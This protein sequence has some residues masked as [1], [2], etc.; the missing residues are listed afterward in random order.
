MRT[1]LATDYGGGLYRRRKA[2]VEPVFAQ[3]KHNRR[4]DQLPA[5]RQIRR[6]LGMA[7]DHRDSQPDEAPQAPASR[8]GGLKRH[9]SRTDTRPGPQLGL[10]EHHCHGRW[11]SPSSCGNFARHPRRSA[12]IQD[13]RPAAL[14]LDS[15]QRSPGRGSMAIGAPPQREPR[16]HSGCLLLGF[17]WL[18]NIPVGGKHPEASWVCGA[19]V[20]QTQEARG[21]GADW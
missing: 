15:K 18:P 9:L 3:T 2:M 12:V 7:T 1:V 16:Q 20:A 8:P 14:L 6:A 21:L 5:T 19:H 13:E 17:G 10:Y 11:H 4:I